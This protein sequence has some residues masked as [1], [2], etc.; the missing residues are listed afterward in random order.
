MRRLLP[1]A[2]QINILLAQCSLGC[3]MLSPNGKSPST[4]AQ[5]L[6]DRTGRL[7]SGT[8]LSVLTQPSFRLNFL[9]SASSLFSASIP[10]RRKLEKYLPENA[11]AELGNG[12]CS[13]RSPKLMRVLPD[14]PVV[15]PFFTTRSLGLLKLEK[16]DAANLDSYLYHLQAFPDYFKRQNGWLLSSMNHVPVF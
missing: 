4:S 6:P 15:G 9:T 10:K 7:T 3:S 1:M 14:S 8:I 11:P 12:P 5:F 13:R 16:V 2:I